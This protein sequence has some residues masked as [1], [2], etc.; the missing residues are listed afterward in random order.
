MTLLAS[1]GELLAAASGLSAIGSVVTGIAAA[2]GLG[3]SAVVAGGMLLAS[4]TPAGDK[5]KIEE[6]L[7]QLN[8]S[9]NKQSQPEN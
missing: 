2:L 9:L 3:P 8:A 5:N 1:G 7:P 6:L 4:T